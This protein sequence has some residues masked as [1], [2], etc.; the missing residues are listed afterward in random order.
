M[1]DVSR[2]RKLFWEDGRKGLGRMVEVWKIGID[3]RYN[4]ESGI[5]IFSGTT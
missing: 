3:K 1:K 2:N 5:G 4:R